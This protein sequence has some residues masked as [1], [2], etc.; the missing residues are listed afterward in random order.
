MKIQNLQTII[1]VLLLAALSAML[2][3]SNSTSDQSQSIAYVD[4]TRLFN[5]FI[6]SQELKSKLDAK[7]ASIR[8]ELD[9]LSAIVSLPTAT[10]STVMTYRQKLDE[11]SQLN[12]SLDQKYSGIIWEQLNIYT[13]EF[14]SAHGYDMILGNSGN[15]NVMHAQKDMDVTD[16][17]LKYANDQF[18]GL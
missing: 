8:A 3:L 14:G 15:G 16:A 4:N 17:I 10:Q 5:D 12:S 11:Y 1:I 7:T 13:Q 6:G 18:Q 2:F 9:S